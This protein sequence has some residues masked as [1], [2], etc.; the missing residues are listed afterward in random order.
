M[1][2]K[3]KRLILIAVV[4]ILILIVIL[5]IYVYLNSSKF[6]P[7]I[8]NFCFPLRTAMIDDFEELHDIKTLKKEDLIELLGRRGLGDYGAYI[9]YYLGRQGIF[10]YFYQINFNEDGYCVSAVVYYD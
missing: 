1:R 9:N 2:R 7:L 6:N 4:F 10:Q 3:L 8:W 5:A